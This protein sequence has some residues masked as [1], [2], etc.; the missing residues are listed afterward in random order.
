SGHLQ[1]N[2][3]APV[4]LMGDIGLELLLGHQ[5]NYDDM[6]GSRVRHPQLDL[7]LYIGPSAHLMFE[8]SVAKTQTWQMLRE[9]RNR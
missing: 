7:E 4:W 5:D 6:L 9:L 1:K 3:S 8:N 2:E